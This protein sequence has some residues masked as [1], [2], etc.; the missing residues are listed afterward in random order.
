M[1]TAEQLT[2]IAQI[3]LALATLGGVIM[4]NIKAN[5]MNGH[6][7]DVL[8]STAQQNKLEGKVEILEKVIPPITNSMAKTTVI[9]KKDERREP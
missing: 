6:L 2:G 1:P 3:I 8:S 5:Q 4:Q 7:K 9:H